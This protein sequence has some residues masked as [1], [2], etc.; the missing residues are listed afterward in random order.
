MLNKLKLEVLCDLFS[1]SCDQWRLGK[2]YPWKH[3]M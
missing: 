2:S 1:P 3:Q